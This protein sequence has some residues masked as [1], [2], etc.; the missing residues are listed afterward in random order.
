MSHKKNCLGG[1]SVA[2][3][4]LL[5]CMTPACVF[6]AEPGTKADAEHKDWTLVWSDEFNGPDG[7]L[8]DPNKWT[9]VTGGSGYGNRELESYTDR[10]LN[11]HQ[12]KGN[13]VIT[14]RKEGF[15]GVDGNAREY[16]S[17]RLQTKGLFEAQYGR[18]E[19]RIKVPDG[20]GIWPAFWM[21][22]GNFDTVQWPDCGEIDI[23]E[24]IGSEPA[25]VYGSLHGPGYSGSE[26]LTRGYALPN[27]ARFSDAFHLFAIEWEPNVIRFYVDGKLFETQSSATLPPQRRWAFNHPFYVLLNVAVGGYWPGEPNQTTVFPASMLVDYVRVYKPA[28]ANT[29]SAARH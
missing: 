20:Q 25:K 17:A 12:E 28:K 3:A 9:L 7:S 4:A 26:P 23:M 16:T 21:M 15:T 11:V 22:G 8:P 24:H 2:I 18:I 13:L 27:D 10:P 29:D 1:A 14:A 19:A 6:A 5:A